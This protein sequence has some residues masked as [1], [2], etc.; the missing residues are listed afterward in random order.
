MTSN[1]QVIT[2]ILSIV[3]FMGSAIRIL[4]MSSNRSKIESL[5][6]AESK[7]KW[8]FFIELLIFVFLIFFISQIPI[9]YYNNIISEFI[10]TCL[11]IIV[12]VVIVIFYLVMCS[13][14]FLKST[15]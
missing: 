1:L 2:G 12:I 10:L 6:T 14:Y 7:N 5:L 15:K 9:F 8:D 13:L 4:I 11:F 3:I